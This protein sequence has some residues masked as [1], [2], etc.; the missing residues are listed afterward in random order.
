MSIDD[1]EGDWEKEGAR[2]HS[3]LLN[4]IGYAIIVTDLQE[5]VIYCHNAAAQ[6]HGWSREEATGQRLEENQRPA[7]S[8]GPRLRRSGR[9]YGRDELARG[10][11]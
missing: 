5:R 6:L 10:S 4:T 1:T 3:W 11:L 9:S 8:C 7:K 2:F